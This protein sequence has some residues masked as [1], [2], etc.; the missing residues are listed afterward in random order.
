MDIDGGIYVS[1]SQLAI[2]YDG[3]TYQPFGPWLGFSSVEE[4][5]NFQISK[6][7]IT[8]SGLPQHDNNGETFI[9]QFLQHDYVDK[10]VKIHRVFYDEYDQ[11]ITDGS[12]VMQGTL[13]FDGYIDRPTIEDDPHSQT[14]VGVEVSNHWVDFDR[15]AGRHSN[16]NEHKIF[17]PGDEFFQ[18]AKRTRRDIKWQPPQ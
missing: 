4:T 3:N 5:R 2:D 12:G 17:A 15:T 11:P 7:T 14:T 18:Y 9:S 13:I 16:D 6:I 10:R 1:N 8:L